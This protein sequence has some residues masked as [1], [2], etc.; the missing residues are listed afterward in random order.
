MAFRRS[1]ERRGTPADLVVLGLGN[2][3]AEYA[4]SRHNVGADVV[5][6]LAE[7]H[8]G[9]LKA[10][11]KERSLVA[12]VRIGHA[13]RHGAAV[14]NGAREVVAGTVL[15]LRGGNAREVV[16]AVKQRV[17]T[18]Q[19][20]GLLPDRPTQSSLL[21]R[22]PSNERMQQRIPG[23]PDGR[24][25]RGAGFLRSC[26]GYSRSPSRWVPCC[27]SGN[28]C[29]CRAGAIRR[30]RNSRP[31]GGPPATSTSIVRPMSSGPSM[32]TRSRRGCT[33]RP[34]GT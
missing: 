29:I 8:G 19:R 3:G 22:C 10:S 14:L 20:D 7:R 24:A 11:T 6:L 25:C 1:P 15:M 2:P 18:I 32:A 9:R 5:E 31:F 33:L 26:R 12:E 17:E 28:G 21:S 16:E 34:A 27:R 13:V 30:R 23:D 4:H